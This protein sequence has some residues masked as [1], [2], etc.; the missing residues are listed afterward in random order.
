MKE[1]A[2]FIITAQLVDDTISRAVR[3][4]E[5]VED[6]L[7]CYV[8]KMRALINV[9][10]NRNPSCVTPMI[11]FHVWRHGN[12]P[13]LVYDMGE[14]VFS[15]AEKLF[16]DGIISWT[17]ITALFT[18]AYNV[19][20]TIW[21]NIKLLCQE[22]T[23]LIKELCREIN[24]GLRFYIHARLRSWIENNGGWGEFIYFTEKYRFYKIY[25]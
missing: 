4:E 8:S 2:Y 25:D 6:S 7:N 5:D 13:F 21:I 1:S 10:C 19:A 12:P 23:E 18:L 9:M 20:R 3:N 11:P 16:S 24:S 17:R 22:N 14:M 15:L